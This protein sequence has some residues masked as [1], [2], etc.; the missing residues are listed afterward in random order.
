MEELTAAILSDKFGGLINPRAVVAVP[1]GWHMI[2]YSALEKLDN[3]PSSIRAFMLV[4]GIVADEHGLLQVVLAAA[5]EYWPEGAAETV[6]G[7]IKDARNL[8]AWSCVSDGN[9]GWLVHVKGRPRVLC[10]ECQEKSSLEVRR[11]EA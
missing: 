10:P 2:V 4:E 6:A 8:A 9:P 3:L 11:H 7:I 1:F 5:A